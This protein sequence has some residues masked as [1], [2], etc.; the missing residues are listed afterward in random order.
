V[1]DVSEIQECKKWIRTVLLANVD[2]SNVVGTRIY[3]DRAP[4]PLVFPFVLFNYLGG[5]DVQGLGTN[6]QQ[7]QPL[8]QVRIVTDGAP[9]ANARKADKRIDDVLQPTKNSASGDYLFSARRE[10][11]VDRAEFDRE[12]NHYYHNLGGL[13][14]VWIRRAA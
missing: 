3:A 2:I 8:F 9:D 6:R 12:T 4:G 1:A 11:P 7:T 10:Q 14:R 13:Y 5:T